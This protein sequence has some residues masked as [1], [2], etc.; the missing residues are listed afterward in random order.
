[1]VNRLFCVRMCFSV[2][3]QSGTSIASDIGVS[4]AH[5]RI[6]LFMC[7]LNFNWI[8][9]FQCPCVSVSVRVL[10]SG[11]SPIVCNFFCL[12]SFDRAVFAAAA[13]AA[14]F[15]AFILSSADM[16]DVFFSRFLFLFFLVVVML[17]LCR[18]CLCYGR[19]LQSANDVYLYI[20]HRTY[21]SFICSSF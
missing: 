9:I 3:Q 7:C 12:F 2:R 5:S 19:L 17:V 8:S 20:F 21:F 13:A 16:V 6:Y 18:W 15:A 14:A 4:R 10:V 11:W 1:M